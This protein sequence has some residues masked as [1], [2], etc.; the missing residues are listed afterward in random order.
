MMR[1]HFLGNVGNT[2]FVLARGLREMGIDA[3]LYFNN[4]GGIDEPSFEDPS[5]SDRSLPDWIVRLPRQYQ[6]WQPRWHVAK[7]VLREIAQCD[8]I[9]AHGIGTIWA[10]MTGRPFIWH[11]FGGDLTMNMRYH[12]DQLIRWRKIGPATVPLLAVPYVFLPPKMHW[13]VRRASAIALPWHNALWREGYRTILSLGVRD[14]IRRIHFGIDT[15]R[16]SP[17]SDQER[18][19][20]RAKLLPP[21]LR[22][23]PLIFH[24][25]RQFFS[26]PR[27]SGFK[28]NDR[29]YRALAVLAQTDL[30]FTL[31]LIEKG[32]DVAPARKLIE[33]LGISDKVHWVQNMPRHRLVDWYRASD[34]TAE[35]FFTGAI[36]AVPMESMAC[37]TPVLMHIQMKEEPEDR[38]FFTDPHDLYPELPPIIRAREQSEIVDALRGILS[39]PTQMARLRQ[40]SRQWV[41]TYASVPVACARLLELDHAI[42]AGHA[43]PHKPIEESAITGDSLKP[44]GP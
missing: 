9:H 6:P 15:S 41:E 8:M 5:L 35:S 27:L 22:D 33:E 3:R 21:G 42:L 1:I 20:L 25:V 7:D 24:P 40:D 37:G 23:S 26:K 43:V 32:F 36:G 12:W 17:V 14:R 11:P 18:T 31:V 34:I 29:L 44:A 39:N 30:P 38:G 13:A 28:A 19:A 16:F 4:E 2:H 10:A